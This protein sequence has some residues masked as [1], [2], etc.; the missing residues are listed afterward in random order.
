MDHQAHNVNGK[1]DARPLSAE[2][3][4]AALHSKFS[5]NFSNTRTI[6]SLAGTLE[7][8]ARALS[9][10]GKRLDSL[11][12]DAIHQHELAKYID[13]I[14]GDSMCATYLSC[15]GL[16]VAA[17]MLLRRSLELGLV[18]AAYWDAPV[19][20]WNWREH[21]GDIRF[22]TLCAYIESDGYTTLC[23]KQG[24]SEEVD[25][26][27]TIKTLERLYSVL[28]NVVHPKP[29]N[30]STTQERMYTADP[31]EVRKTLGYAVETQ[32]I[33]ATILCWRFPDFNDILTSA[34]K[35]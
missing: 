32:Q 5:A 4:L 24:K 16:D 29:Y 9:L 6:H 30:F 13:E 18:V 33:I 15:C 3:L 20:F 25:V 12:G 26:K 27:P 14:F 31:E 22:T 35:K 19:D 34:P 21:D 23:R 28:S 10:A 7:A 8:R 2:E 17:R 1:P 11:A